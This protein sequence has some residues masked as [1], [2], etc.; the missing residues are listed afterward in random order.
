MITSH[1]FGT[2]ARPRPGGP[3]GRRLGFGLGLLAALAAGAA[4]CGASRGV[5]LGEA[6][7]MESIREFDLTGAKAGW[8]VEF[9]LFFPPVR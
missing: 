7:T 4:L 2:A 9:C 3:L 8:M 1:P 5:G 6:K